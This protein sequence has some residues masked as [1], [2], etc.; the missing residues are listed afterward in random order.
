MGI[1]I[2]LIVIG[3]MLFTAFVVPIMA[4]VKCINSDLSSKSKTWWIIG[5]FFTWPLTSYI[6]FVVH[7]KTMPRRV[8]SFI[9]IVFLV[10][11]FVAHLYSDPEQIENPSTSN[12]PA[13]A[14][15]PH[16]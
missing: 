8:L 2:M 14:S 15:T 6:Y 12:A 3:L 9:V 16:P 11:A 1:V 10:I 4:I 13:N 5:M 7:A